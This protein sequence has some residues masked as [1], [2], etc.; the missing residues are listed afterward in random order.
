MLESNVTVCQ[1]NYYGLRKLKYLSG[2]GILIGSPVLATALDFALR[3]GGKHWRV[4]IPMYDIGQNYISSSPHVPRGASAI[5]CLSLMYFE[6]F[7]TY[8]TVIL[9]E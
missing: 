6:I 9:G 7:F 4:G 8:R 1:K 5:S 3:K 2:R